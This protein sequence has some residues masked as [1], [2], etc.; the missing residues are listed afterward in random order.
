[1]AV[2]FCMPKNGMDMTEGTIVRWLKKEGDPVEKDEP[3]VEIETDK[4]TM[5]AETPVSGVLLK[6]LYPDGAVVPV[7][8]A[9]AYI[10]QPGEQLPEETAAAPEAPQA[11]AQAAPAAVPAGGE[12]AY[13]VAVI[14]GGPAGYV[15]AIRAAQ[16]GA[17][18][19]LFERDEIGGTC[20]NR[21]CIPTKSFMRT[22]EYLHHIRRAGERGIALQSAP[23]VRM[24]EVVACKDQAVRTLTGGVRALLRS[25]GVTVIEGR[26][27]LASAHQIACGDTVYTAER[28]ILCG[29]SRT[30]LPRIP[31]ME[32]KRVLTSTEILNLREVPG[33]LCV[34]GGGV[35]GCELASAFRAFGSQVTI[36]EMLDRLVA[37]MDGEISREL[38][39]YM[40]RDGI[41]V[42]LGKGVRQVEEQPDGHLTVTADDLKIE[43]DYVLVSV[44][45][46]PDLDCLG[47]LEGEIRVEKGRV[48]VDDTMRTSV[49]SVYA[50]GDINGRAMLAHAAFRM[51]EVA[52]E[53]CVTGG[54]EACHLEYVPNV[55]Y[56]VPECAGIG[57][58]E[59]QARERYADVRIGKFPLSANS[60]AVVSGE[61][62]GFVK[63][64]IDGA[65]GEILGVHIIG[66]LASE[67]I[68]EPTALMTAEVTVQ[69]VVSRLI[70]THPSYA[71]AFGEACGDVLNRCIHL[72]ARK[73]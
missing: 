39:K 29:G 63:V 31:G 17:K 49:E 9:I 54:N 16:L 67:M 58:T 23:E 46:V 7:L 44:G 59:E 69:E 3:I 61:P 10:G 21:G 43:C 72:P 50:C 30:V 52:A 65:Y 6:R 8:T 64:V 28:I 37:P 26:A 60:R 27:A 57:L 53:N 33:R 47:A 2:E 5:E 71:E 51:G 68:A 1:M 25:R 41:E 22:A 14:G 66:G 20:L 62:D 40:R 56:A 13:Q 24:P 34:I 45:R 18:V 32:S 55:L 70:H 42:H 73:R 19:V 12:N 36:V 15:A 35:I 11:P 48:V 4:I 38:L